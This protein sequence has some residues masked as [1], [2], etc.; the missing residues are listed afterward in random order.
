M[1]V[2]DRFRAYIEGDLDRL[3]HMDSTVYGLLADLSLGFTNLAW[4]RFAADN[5]SAP[6]RYPAPERR[7]LAAITPELSPFYERMFREVLVRR[8][9]AEHTYACHSPDL[10]RR[11]RMR[12]LPAGAGLIVV[13]HLVV[14]QPFGHGDAQP[15]VAQRYTNADGLITQCCQCRMIRRPATP[16]TWDWVPAFLDTPPEELT[17]GLCPLCFRHYYPKLAARYDVWQ[18]SLVASG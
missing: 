8:E 16:R 12:V 18:A 5:S 10:F 15:P 6:L 11:Y 1:F 7:L 3:V 2:D 13:H 17:H 9:P 4:D 14:E